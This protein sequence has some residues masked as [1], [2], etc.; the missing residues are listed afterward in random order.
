MRKDITPQSPTARP[1]TLYV[2]A[3]PI[4][5]LEDITLRA[6]RIL[7]EVDGIAA[8]DTRHTRKLLSHL[9][10]SKPLLSYYKDKEVSR[11]EQI[12]DRLRNGEDIALVSDAGTP[13]ISD[14]GHIITRIAHDAGIRVVPIPGPS[15][16]TAA[17]SVAGL[18]TGAFLFLGFLPSRSAARRRF[19]KTIAHHPYSCIFY[20]SPQRLPACLQDCYEILGERSIFW[21]RE[22]TKVHEEMQIST[23]ARLAAETAT[24]RIRGESV[25]I[26][27][28]K[29]AEEKLASEELDELLAWYNTETDLSLKDAVRKVAEDLDLPRS[30]VYKK[31]LGIWKG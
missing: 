18:T 28:G 30:A 5:N 24:R 22:L 16:L 7:G 1:G 4:G 17:L 9:G 14:P 3:T 12:L 10:I 21:G 23:L 15:A 29:E 31:A 2:V 20:E 26:I 6:I 25:I 27:Q 13:A 19:L 8:E 11:G